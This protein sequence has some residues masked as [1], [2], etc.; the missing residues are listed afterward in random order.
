M[1]AANSAFK[2]TA[3]R[4]APFMPGRS[5]P[6][7][8]FPSGRRT[9]CN[10]SNNLWFGFPKENIN[11]G[12]LLSPERKLGPALLLSAVLYLRELSGLS[13]YGLRLRG[14]TSSEAVFLAALSRAR[15]SPG[16]S[17]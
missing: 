5:A 14:W 15:R 9:F 7:S 11:R 3:A 6:H 4:C 8:S 10:N 13:I 2:R 1:H 16:I 12:Y 17:A